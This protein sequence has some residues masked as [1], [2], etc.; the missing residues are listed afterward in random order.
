MTVDEGHC[1]PLAGVT[2]ARCLRHVRPK[3]A[4]DLAMFT[5]I[6][7]LGRPSSSAARPPRP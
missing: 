7:E 4:E 6:V 5:T 1:R 3:S 2:T